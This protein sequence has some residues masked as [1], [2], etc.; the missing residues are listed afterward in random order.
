[1]SLGRVKYLIE[2]HLL[3]TEFV[4]LFIL[5]EA[6]KL[7]EDNFQEQINWIFSSLPSNK[8]MMAFS[9]TYPEYLAKHL[10]RYM[11]EPTFVRL[12]ASDPT[13][14]GIQQFYQMVP[15]HPLPHKIFQE[16]ICK[17]LKLLSS[18]PF[19]Q[20]LVFSNYRIRA[21]SLCDTLRLKGWPSVFIAG[22]QTQT[23]RLKAMERLKQFKC[24]VLI[25]TDLTSRGIDCENVNIVVNMDVPRDSETYL[26]RIGRAGRFGTHGVA[27][28]FVASGDEEK[29]FRRIEENI[30]TTTIEALPEVIPPSIRNALNGNAEV[31]LAAALPRATSIE[32]DILKSNFK[33]S[34]VAENQE[35][36]NAREV[37]KESNENV[38]DDVEKKA[39]VEDQNSLSAESLVEKTSLSTDFESQVDG[40]TMKNFWSE[41]DVDSSKDSETEEVLIDIQERF[42]NSLFLGQN[43]IKG[44]IRRQKPQSMQTQCISGELQASETDT[45]GKVNFP[46]I[47][48]VS[49]NDVKEN[50]SE[51]TT[52]H[53]QS[54]RFNSSEERLSVVEDTSGK[55]EVGI[56]HSLHLESEI[57]NNM[58]DVLNKASQ[59]SDLHCSQQGNTD[60]I[61]YQNSLEGSSEYEG[62]DSTGTPSS[63]EDISGSCNNS[64]ESSN[65]LEFDASEEEEGLGFVCSMPSVDEFERDF[66]RY[67]ERVSSHLQEDN[68]CNNIPGPS[69]LLDDDAIKSGIN[70]CATEEDNQNYVAATAYAGSQ[71]FNTVPGTCYQRLPKDAASSCYSCYCGQ[72]T[73]VQNPT[74]NEKYN[75]QENSFSEG[76]SDYCHGRNDFHDR[77]FQPVDSFYNSIHC[78]NYD[79][80]QLLPGNYH[81]RPPCTSDAQTQRDFAEGTLGQFADTC[82]TGSYEEGQWNAS[83]YDAYQRQT[84]CIRQ[85]VSF[86]RSVKL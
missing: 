67:L 71:N 22:S 85:F 43:C 8:Q 42:Q 69:K 73:E 63:D 68:A 58:E 26:H 37:S 45:I 62:K 27:V 86:S 53:Q 50:D 75:F 5:D 11:R 44:N 12:N 4:R 39:P 3:K 65:C 55:L 30:G 25:S 40:Q 21:Q 10:T 41:N 78:N 49:C 19:K 59:E 7:L 16:K 17:L 82:N 64:Q 79:P 51:M 15:F 61:I 24:R 81:Y 54:A 23:Q 70:S 35:R 1:M 72:F 28:T 76:P 77:C 66:E 6:D 20:C 33:Q 60:G 74:T 29:L 52:S 47:A 56:D 2:N 84:S 48:E 32:V 31:D 9:A 13:L 36:S 57:V 38:L 83:W 14:Q 80:H 46:D 34:E 18:L